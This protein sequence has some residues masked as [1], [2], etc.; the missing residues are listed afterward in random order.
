MNKLKVFTHFLNSEKLSGIVLIICSLFSVVISNTTAGGGYINFWHSQFA[1]KP[2]E[3]W[4]NDG[5]MTIFFLMVGLEIEREFYAGEL[6]DLRKSMLPVLAATGGMIAPALIHTLF[7]HGTATQGGFGIPMATDIAFTLAVLSLL[8]KRVP[9]SLKIFL[10]ALAII[11]DLGAI[12]VIA[13]FYSHGFSLLYFGLAMVVFVFL[14][15]LNRL[16][17]S[18]TIVYLLM[19]MGMWYFM[20]RAG[21]HPTISGVLLAFAIPFGKGDDNSV[22]IRLQRKLHMVVALLIL[23]LFALANTAIPLAGVRFSDLALPNNLGIILGLTIGKP[24][25]IML[26]SIAGIA[27]GLCHLPTGISRKHLF[28]A[29]C[30]AGIGFTISI[31]IT[32]L[33]FSDPAVTNSSKVSIILAS[34]VSGVIGFTGLSIS[35]KKARFNPERNKDED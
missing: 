15:I 23:P 10:T 21:I 13:I 3:F 31:F 6:S 17:F 28:W 26:F 32:L 14:L 9:L 34:V 19:G 11:D 2:L 20:L 5:L 7:N 22:S 8:G 12:V 4:I 25:G 1:G 35:L 16:R 18:V 29:A 30:L 24:V 27:I 33:A